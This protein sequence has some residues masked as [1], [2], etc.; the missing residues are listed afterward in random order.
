MTGTP[1]AVRPALGAAARR[2]ATLALLALV[3]LLGSAAAPAA[4]DGPVF[5]PA[6][7]RRIL[8][9]GPW[10]PP[11]ARDPSNRVSGQPAAIALGE[12]LF[13]DPRLSRSGA[14]SCATCHVPGQAWADGRPRGVGSAVLDRNTPSLWNVGRQRWFGWDGAGDSLWAQNVRPLLDPMEMA[15]SA[16]HVAAVIRSDP[17]LAC[18]HER[19]FGPGAAS[20]ADEAVLVDA[21]KALAAFL[22]TLTSGRTAFDAF[23]DALAAGDH[24]A[25]GRYPAAARR[26]LK[27]FVGRGHCS[28]CHVG[29]AFTNGEFHD[30]GVPYL[31][32]PGRVDPGRHGGITRLRASRFSLLGPWNDDASGQAATKTRHVDL[33]HRNWGEFKVPGLRNAAHTAPYMHD[34]RLASLRD[35]AR[36]YSELD[37]ERLH[38]DGERILRPLRLA[39][40]EVDDLVAFLETLSDGSPRYARRPDATGCPP[41]TTR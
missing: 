28:L 17:S 23:R 24:A 18:G 21:G 12:R 25:A 30:V 38:A 36:H 14:M 31:V 40:G 6:E 37:E 8:A 41:P 2:P 22:E 33:L 5:E 39:P 35:V 29:P 3:L 7:I 15:A 13:F 9:H 27:L 34:G 19:A 20:A 4:A 26:G 10:P 32:A 16:A 11:P 1:G